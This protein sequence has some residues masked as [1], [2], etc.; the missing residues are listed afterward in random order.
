MLLKNMF[1]FVKV[2]IC[3]LFLCI[4]MS[5]ITS[6]IVKENKVNCNKH[7]FKGVV[8][9][10]AEEEFPLG[11]INAIVL[12]NHDSMYEAPLRGII[13]KYDSSHPFNIG[14]TVVFNINAK[15]EIEHAVNVSAF[16]SKLQLA[17]NDVSYDCI[18]HLKLN[19]HNADDNHRE[20]PFHRYGHIKSSV[21]YNS[22]YNK[23]EVNLSADNNLPESDETYLVSKTLYETL[24]PS[25]GYFFGV[26]DTVDNF[27]VVDVTTQ[28]EH[29]FGDHQ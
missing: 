4:S 19:L 21:N 28:H 10:R 18:T 20:G 12:N 14:D 16:S 11:L 2:N 7:L 8:S 24:N 25:N 29:R 26:I 15:S 27:R 22:T 13:Y 9:I 17:K 3:I 23:I 6:C 1:Y 5:A